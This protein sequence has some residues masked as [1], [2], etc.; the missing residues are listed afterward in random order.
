MTV[1]L[2]DVNEEKNKNKFAYIKYYTYFYNHINQLKLN[3]MKS[4]I[5]QQLHEIFIKQFK[6]NKQLFDAELKQQPM[7][8]GTNGRIIVNICIN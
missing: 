5:N 1:K 2:K 8:I 4:D 6:L 3:T 7:V